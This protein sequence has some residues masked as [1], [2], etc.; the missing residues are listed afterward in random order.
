MSSKSK[1]V[2]V[3]IPNE[4]IA[5]IEDFSKNDPELTVSEFIRV[6]VRREVQALQ[7]VI[8]ESK[9][10]PA[11]DIYLTPEAAQIIDARLSSLGAYDDPPKIKLD[12]E[13]LAE[14]LALRDDIVELKK[15]MA[16]ID[17]KVSG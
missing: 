14:V 11:G 3:I 7:Q 4:L 16:D 13:D 8:A 10:L 12:P 17:K 9:G 2:S 1:T 15:A 5:W 6:C